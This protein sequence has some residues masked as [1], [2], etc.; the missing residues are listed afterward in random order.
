MKHTCVA[1]RDTGDDSDWTCR[2]NDC[3]NPKKS[4]C[5]KHEDWEIENV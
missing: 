3:P 4:L 1:C 5:P 2:K